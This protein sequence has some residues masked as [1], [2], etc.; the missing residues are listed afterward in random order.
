MGIIEDIQRLRHY[1][2]VRCGL[3][4]DYFPDVVSLVS[5]FGLR[6]DAACYCEIDVSKARLLIAEV[7]QRDQAY[8]VEVMPAHQANQ[9]TERFLDQF[10]AQA[11]YFTNKGCPATNATFDTGVVVIGSEL[12]GCLWVEDED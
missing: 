4:S 5:R 11:Q 3:V 6:P 2:V 8:G 12:S 10:D 1:G 7:L 9:L